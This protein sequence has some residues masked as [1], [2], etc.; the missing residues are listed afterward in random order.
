[1]LIFEKYIFICWCIYH[2]LLFFFIINNCQQWAYSE[3]FFKEFVF[4]ITILFTF[5]VIMKALVP[6]LNIYQ[7]LVFKILINTN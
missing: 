2:F 1:M 7:R 3:V 4:A 5:S 6:Q